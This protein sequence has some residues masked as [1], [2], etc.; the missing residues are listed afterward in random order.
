VGD[1]FDKL[2]KDA[3]ADMPRRQAFRRIGGGLLSIVLAAVGLTADTTRSA[4]AQFCVSCCELSF[5]PPRGG[6]EGK[7]YAECIRNCHNGIA[8][9]TSAGELV[10]GSA[11][12]GN[13]CTPNG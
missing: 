13:P 11:T 7:E 5:S 3:A 12:P 2:A 8:T 9:L 4:C 6:G 1:L 10:C